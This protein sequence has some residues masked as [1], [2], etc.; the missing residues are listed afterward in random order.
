MTVFTKTGAPA[1]ISFEEAI[2]RERPELRGKKVK[3][4]ST[5][6]KGYVLI[7]GDDETGYEVFKAPKSSNPSSEAMQDFNMEKKT[8]WNS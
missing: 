1:D 7:I 8:T 4:S 6:Q 2:Y 3:N 5:G